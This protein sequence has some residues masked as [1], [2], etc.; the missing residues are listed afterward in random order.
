[1]KKYKRVITK[2]LFLSMLTCPIFIFVYG[3]S[4]Y[5]L[6][7][8][9]RF[10]RF[11]NNIAILSVCMIFF[12]AW[13]ILF[14]IRAKRN[15]VSV[16]KQII[17]RY[18]LNY[19]GI[20]VLQEELQSGFIQVNFQ[21]VKSFSIN[22]KY[23]FIKLKNKDIL[24]LNM[25]NK[26]PE[27]IVMLKEALNESVRIKPVYRVIWTYLAIIL[28]I[29][30]TLFYGAKIYRSGIKYNGKLSWIIQ[31]LKDK[32]TVEFNH[33]DIYKDGI[34]GIFTDINEKFHMPEKLY[35]SDEFRL[36]FDSDGI[37]TYIDTFIY[38]K[39]DK[40]E[41]KSYLISYDKSSSNKITVYLNRKVYAD[42]NEDK[43]LKPLIDTMKI[44]PLK[45][46]VSKWNEKQYGILYLGKRSWGYNTDGIVYI[47]PEGNQKSPDVVSSEIIENTVS[48][49]VP[50]KE[51]RYTPVRY[52]LVENLNEVKEAKSL[53]S[54]DDKNFSIPIN[55][56]TQEFYLSDKVGYRLV[57]AGAALGSRFY[58]LYGTRDAGATWKV[59]NG[60]PFSGW[61][62][63]AA[64]ITFLN[65]KL[66]FLALSHS[67][68][69]N[70]DLYRTD[71]GG[72]SYKKVELPEVKIKLDKEKTYN[73]FDFPGMPYK[74]DGILK[75]L[76]GQ[77]SDGDYNKVSN[78]LYESKD[79]G[80]TWKYVKEVPRDS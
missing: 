33:N 34:E 72:L 79:E 74:E 19:N 2:R 47:D 76:V 38:G 6:N 49:F 40:G 26:T 3:I 9:A 55:K 1:M 10:G 66:G 63:G 71:D 4:F 11:N 77:G 54:D 58:A 57:E 56:D 67:G 12:L 52:N 70:A 28:I 7:T 5:E 42:Y 48:V 41:L 14:I 15:P 60:D 50:G 17:D 69:S 51:T 13:L 53:Q 37:I 23:G 43:L 35:V 59:I 68:G 18:E 46:T 80:K 25:L 29:F 61:S 22:K 21:D 39:N 24:V 64:G 32:K 30:I 44:I 45:Q 8:L 36:Y 16:P 75:I 78:A 62:G 20:N 65:D 31:D 73:P 27:E